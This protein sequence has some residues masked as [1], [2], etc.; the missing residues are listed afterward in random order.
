M[1]K[2]YNKAG[3]RFEMQVLSQMARFLQL[4]IFTSFYDD[5]Y[6]AILMMMPP[7]LPSLTSWFGV[8]I[9]SDISGR[10]VLDNTIF[11]YGA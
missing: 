3:F 6:E 5:E 8:D 10:S 4:I 9:D 11:R 2:F 7:Q 1:I